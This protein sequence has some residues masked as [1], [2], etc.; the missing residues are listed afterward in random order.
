MLRTS[1]IKSRRFRSIVLC[2]GTKLT[3]LWKTL[4]RTSR[5]KA[6]VFGSAPSVIRNS[7][8]A[9]FYPNIWS[10]VMMKSRS[11][12][13]T[14][15]LETSDRD[16]AALQQR[17]LQDHQLLYQG[18][19]Q[20]QEELCGRVQERTQE[21]R[22]LPRLRRTWPVGRSEASSCQQGHGQLPGHLI[23]LPIWIGLLYALIDKINIENIK[24]SFY[25]ADRH[26]GSG[27]V[28]SC[29]FSW[30]DICWWIALYCLWY[31]PN[32]HF[33]RPTAPWCSW[34][35]SLSFGSSFPIYQSIFYT[36]LFISCRRCTGS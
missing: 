30:G 17:S 9:N 23:I 26:L 35:Y 10:L 16:G 20:G 13:D 34:R 22:E 36:T 21:E 32:C 11:R 31:H 14:S 7:R 1:S 6:K 19:E 27:W 24:C 28:S 2:W 8:A 33:S 5:M 12:Y 3:N 25:S 29:Q 18:R 4:R 15:Y